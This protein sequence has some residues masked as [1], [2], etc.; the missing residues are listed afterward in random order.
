MIDI[1]DLFAFVVFAV[2]VAAALVAVVELGSLPGS[3]ARKRA[4]PQ[5]AA[6]NVADWL[7]LATGGLLWPLALIWAFLVPRP[8]GPFGSTSDQEPQPASD[9]GAEEPLAQMQARVDALQAALRE[10]RARK[11]V[12][13]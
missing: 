5:A 8:A 9:P 10:L 13:S 6:I 3:I 12:V 1:F 4:H 7:G 11:G 2:L